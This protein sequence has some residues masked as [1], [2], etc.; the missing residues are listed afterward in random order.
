[1]RHRGPAFAALIL[2][3]SQPPA[4]VGARNLHDRR[5]RRFGNC[6]HHVSPLFNARQRCQL[7]ATRGVRSS[8]AARQEDL[9]PDT[10][11]CAFGRVGDAR[12]LG[13]KSTALGYPVLGYPTPESSLAGR[14][15]TRPS[16]LSTP[17]LLSGFEPVGSTL[18]SSKQRW[19]AASAS[20]SPTSPSANRER[21][22]ST[23]SSYWP[24]PRSTSCLLSIFFLFKKR[25]E[26][27][28]DG[29]RARQGWDQ[30]SLSAHLDG[31]RI[32]GCE[33]RI[34]GK[35]RDPTKFGAEVSASHRQGHHHGRGVQG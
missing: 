12:G 32:L 11:G 26:A 23:S 2:I 24:S 7:Q 21:G 18:A 29:H 3:K 4:T 10:L 19:L 28:D 14:C 33:L 1:M 5:F 8:S 31:S 13:C 22:G 9:L 35:L 27:G 25:K 6:R 34:G 16:L 30:R 20:P 15:P 17:S